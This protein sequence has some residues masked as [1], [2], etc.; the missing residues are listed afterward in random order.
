MKRCHQSEEMEE[1][2]NLD[3][4]FLEVKREAGKDN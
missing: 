3:N 4:W 1:G 2:E